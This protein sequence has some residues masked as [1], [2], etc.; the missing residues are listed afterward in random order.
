MSDKIALRH[1]V[2]AVKLE[3]EQRKLSRGKL[4]RAEADY[5]LSRLDA[6]VATL[7]W[8][9]TNEDRIKGALSS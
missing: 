3:L 4:S 2:A 9:E 6:A 8:L 1:Q 7:E 5:Q